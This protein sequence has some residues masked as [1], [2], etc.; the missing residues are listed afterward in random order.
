MT[1]GRGRPG[2]PRK[3]A[4]PGGEP[5][6][7]GGGATT[8]AALAR[9]LQILALFD[10]AHPEW[11]LNDL[12]EQTRL[13]K[14]TVYRLVRT[15]E[16]HRFLGLDRDTGFYH[17]GLAAYRVAFLADAHAELVQMAR[18]HLQA[19][20]EATGETA[21]I[22]VEREDSAVVLDRI[23]TSNPFKPVFHVGQIHGLFGNSHGKI[24]LA[25]KN[26]GERERFFE[27]PI[28]AL[29]PNAVVDREL[30]ERE[31]DRIAAEGAAYDLEEESLG[32]CGV[33]APVWG[34]GGVLVASMSVVAPRERFGYAEQRR[35]ADAVKAEAAALS[36]DLDRRA[37]HVGE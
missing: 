6:P 5:T 25:F 35:Y 3:V 1:T 31:L 19:L 14:S 4:Q 2:R 15:L 22:A 7:A 32:F 37:S 30:Y 11:S 27:H 17:L 20:A 21:T 23:L 18:P 9:G 29:T 16:D 12:V 33:S 8:I 36:R 28:P 13:H 34:P 24:F 26:A 10:K